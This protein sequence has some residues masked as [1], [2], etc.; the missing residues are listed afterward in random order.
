L[1]ISPPLSPCTSWVLF[2][3]YILIPF[4]CR[5]P[6]NV[7]MSSSRLSK[8]SLC[9]L[10]C[11]LYH[12]ASEPSNR[13]LLIVAAHSES[14]FGSFSTLQESN[15]RVMWLGAQFI[16]NHYRSGDDNEAYGKCRLTISMAYGNQE[17]GRCAR[18]PCGSRCDKARCYIAS[19]V[20]RSFSTR[21]PSRAVAGTLPCGTGI[22]SAPSCQESPGG[23]RTD[24]FDSQAWDT[25][26]VVHWHP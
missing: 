9:R 25:S 22:Q 13:V 3:S 12:D 4:S 1:S 10:L 24:I 17:L 11:P 20:I 14:V 7:W 2:P 16:A 5:A 19:A 15:R 6:V 23:Q 26:T 21:N 18:H 8:F